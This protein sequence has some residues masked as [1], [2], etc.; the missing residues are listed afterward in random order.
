MIKLEKVEANNFLS[1][2]NVSLEL[3][4]QGLVMIDGVNQSADSFQANGAGK[5][6][7]MSTI[8]YGLYGITLSDQKSDDVINLNAKKNCWV[9]LY[10]SI[11]N[12]DYRIERYRKDSENKNKVK[13]FANDVEITD[14]SN[15]KTE[16]IIQR[17][18]GIDFDTYTNAVIYS[19]SFAANGFMKATDKGKKEILNTIAG[20]L[21]YDQAREKSKEK[22]EALTNKNNDI[23][24]SIYKANND[25]EALKSNYDYQNKIYESSMAKKSEDIKQLSDS[26][27]SYSKFINV[28]NQSYQDIENKLNEFKIKK[29]NM[30]KV[31]IESNKVKAKLS[32]YY[33]KIKYNKKLGKS[34]Y[35]LY[36]SKKDEL[37]SFKGSPVCPVCGAK[38]DKDHYKKEYSK[39]VDSISKLVNNI[40]KYKEV[41]NEDTIVFNNLKKDY[42]E[43]DK[44][45]YSELESNISNLNAKLSQIDN[46]KYELESN[47]KANQKI[48]DSLILD[49]PKFDNVKET[50][51]IDQLNKLNQEKD[52][53]NTEIDKYNILAKEVF[54]DSGIKNYVFELIIPFINQKANE[55]LEK[56]TNGQINIEIQTQ[57][58]TKSG[59]LRE[60]MDVIVTNISGAN[61]YKSCSAGEKKRIDLSISFAIQD[62]LLS[63]SNLNINVFIYDECFDGLD[64]I[65]CENVIDILRD[66]GNNTGT[67][68][69]ITHNKYLKPLFNNIITVVKDAGGNS[70]IEN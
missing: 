60:K 53:I 23:D 45:E 48:V 43:V 58:E 9:K 62:L 40:K 13:L 26:K 15:A 51:L 17:L 1:F 64:S 61:S 47:V 12:D 31:G 67:T 20:T 21:V 19:D 27:E 33:N 57:S 46:K 52:N 56:L 10:L 37:T 5:S 68:F 30:D 25:I 34:D 6:S 44:K 50:S 24:K 8:V 69:V 3:D 66:K 49:K 4:N 35:T 29:T 54:S 7:L 55:Y 32:D 16:R 11:N 42:H 36:L 18:I 22:I 63:K 41:I 38:L 14:S 59:S 28:Y 70:K 39:I 65:G 2:S